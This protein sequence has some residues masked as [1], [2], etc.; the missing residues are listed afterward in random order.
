MTEKILIKIRSYSH[1]KFWLHFNETR[2]NTQV[3]KNVKL[4]NY[5]CNFWLHSHSSL[6]S[7]LGTYILL[8]N[9]VV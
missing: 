1:I 4:R 3:A 9:A 7:S 8:Q 5:F 2:I 6:V